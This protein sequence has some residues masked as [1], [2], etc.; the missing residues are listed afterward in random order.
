MRKRGAKKPAP[1]SV[2]VEEVKEEPVKSLSRR[3]A[4]DLKKAVE[5]TEKEM[6]EEEKK[7]DIPAFLRRRPNNNE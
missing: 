1:V 3:N 5:E 4:L 2:Q 7:W 6:Q